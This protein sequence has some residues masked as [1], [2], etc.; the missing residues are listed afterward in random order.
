MAT[1][2]SANYQTGTYTYTR[3]RVDYSGTSA[4]ATLLYTRTNAWY[5]PTSAT[6]ATFTFGGA[7]VGFNK[8]F[9]GPQTD[10]T[11]ASVSFTISSS[12]GTYSGST[13]GAGL[14]SFSGSVNIPAQS[15]APTGLTAS[16]LITYEDGFKATVSISSWGTGATSSRYKEFEVWNY[17]TGTLTN[18]Y[19]L[20]RWGGNNLSDDMTVRTG[21]GFDSDMNNNFGTLDIVANT[22]YTLALRCNNGAATTGNVIWRDAVTLA[23]P[24]HIVLDSV[25]KTSA[26][27]IANLKA[28]GGFYEKHLF[29]S[30]D[31]TNWIAAGTISAGTAVSIPFT[32]GGL[33]AETAYTL[34]TK[35]VT[36]AGESA[37]TDFP[38][39]TSAQVPAFY[40][41]DIIQRAQEAGRFYASVGGQ[42]TNVKK[43]YGSVNGQAQV[44][45]DRTMSRTGQ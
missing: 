12:G 6:G 35:V 13:S 16:N 29:Y 2:Y 11:V 36:Y 8:S 41:S 37:G 38:F 42:A 15:S 44:V 43:I 17:T 4:T 10:A 24:P 7:S 18:P 34:K 28:D 20:R 21:V 30:L 5:D 40:G 9:S 31:G 14:F 27:F 23:Y 32:V 45:F 1:V 3:V 22:R 39:Y 19:R 33:T 26:N 25:S